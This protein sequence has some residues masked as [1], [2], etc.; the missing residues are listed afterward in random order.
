MSKIGTVRIQHPSSTKAR[1][2]I[3]SKKDLKINAV[4]EAFKGK[5][6]S[7]EGFKTT[8]P[9]AEQPIDTKNFN[10]GCLGAVLRITDLLPKI[11][12]ADFD[13]VVSME[14]S[15]NKDTLSETS[16]AIIYNIKEMRFNGY[17]NS[18]PIKS[19]KLAEFKGFLKTAE[20]EA[21]KANYQYLQ[22]G[23]LTTIG[24]LIYKKYPN[25]PDTD[26][27]EH[28]STIKINRTKQ[29]IDSLKP[30]NKFLK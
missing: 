16:N 20:E 5:I 27:L 17:S 2:A 1:I 11:N 22:Y 21:K 7:I 29:L 24:K 30:L 12:Q 6:S 13:Y 14:N 15:I 19:A 8:A 10:I 23:Y 18:I 26:W 9:M 25:I 4:K 28:Y 3:T